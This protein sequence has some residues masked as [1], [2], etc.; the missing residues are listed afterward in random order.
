MGLLLASDGLRI[1]CGS[2]NELSECASVLVLGAA[3]FVSRRPQGF[4]S[5]PHAASARG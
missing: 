4:R 3:P 2:A 5:G 1:V